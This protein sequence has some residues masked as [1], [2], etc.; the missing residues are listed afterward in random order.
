MQKRKGEKNN[1]KVV[2]EQGEN[3]TKKKTEAQIQWIDFKVSFIFLG[4]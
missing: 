4:L 2:A 1:N 3:K